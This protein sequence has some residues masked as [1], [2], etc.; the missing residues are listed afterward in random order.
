LHRRLVEFFRGFGDIHNRILKIAIFV[1]N[2][3]NIV[4]IVCKKI[5]L[6]EVHEH[7]SNGKQNK[8]IAID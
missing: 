5:R 6:P 2:L 8:F 4:L 1:K 7:Y 3:L